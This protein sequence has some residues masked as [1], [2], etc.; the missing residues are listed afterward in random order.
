VDGEVDAAFGQGFFY[1]LDE[2]A[3]AA[4]QGREGF[5][6]GFCG[7]G[8]LHA[9]A[10]GA[11]DF[12]LDS[13]VGVAECGGDVVGLPESELRASGANADGFSHGLLSRI[14]YELQVVSLQVAG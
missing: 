9:V 10:G 14:R 6:G 3:L 1:F 11:D 7:F 12:D 13:V 4:G 2:D 5:G 8:L